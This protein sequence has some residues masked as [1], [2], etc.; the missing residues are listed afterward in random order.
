MCGSAGVLIRWRQSLGYGY[1]VGLRMRA[2]S[3]LASR[4]DVEHRTGVDR[5]LYRARLVV[6]RRAGLG[7]GP[8]RRRPCSPALVRISR[9]LVT[10]P[11]CPQMPC[12]AF[13]GLCVA[14][15][16][17]EAA[18]S[19]G[20]IRVICWPGRFA[21]ADTAPIVV[22]C[23]PLSRAWCIVGRQQGC[24]IDGALRVCEQNFCITW[25]ENST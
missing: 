1:V 6:A 15:P 3:Q 18:A 9:L 2:A 5:V 4:G 19:P 8:K 22:M 25:F 21:V 13:D 10:P 24:G 23:I 14:V 17:G 11:D 20:D 12:D 7:D 16:A